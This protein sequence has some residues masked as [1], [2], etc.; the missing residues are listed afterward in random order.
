MPASVVA[1]V[2]PGAVDQLTAGHLGPAEDASERS[3]D[4]RLRCSASS[5]RDTTGSGSQAPGDRSRSRE[6]SLSQSI[7][8]RVVTAISQDS[9]LRP[10]VSSSCHRRYVVWRTSSASATEPSIR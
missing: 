8:S 9:G 4:S 10:S 5:G 1:H 3:T 7:D 2:L 6:A